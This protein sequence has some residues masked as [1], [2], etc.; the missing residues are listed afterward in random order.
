MLPKA[1]SLPLKLDNLF[2]LFVEFSKEIVVIWEQYHYQRIQ[3][4]SE[5]IFLDFCLL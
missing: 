4:E 2:R 5:L 3:N 1:F